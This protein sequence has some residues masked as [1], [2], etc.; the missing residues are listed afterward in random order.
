MVSLARIVTVRITFLVFLLDRV[1]YMDHREQDSPKSAVPFSDVR[2]QRYKPLEKFWPYADLSEEH[3]DEE[4]LDLDP[5]LRA[6]L[7]GN[8]RR[9][10]SIVLVFPKFDSPD[11][12]QAVRLARASAE[13]RE[14]G[15]D[16]NFRHRAR[17]YPEEAKQLHELFVIV[18][19]L[20]MCDVL[21]DDKPVPYARELWLPLIWFLIPRSTTL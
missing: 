10:F 4:I 20:D 3:S 5:E 17:F 15:R 8:A 21:I 19:H 13:Y 1:K 18:E 12:D 2:A 16:S 7:F 9:P 6:E 11:Y 14:S